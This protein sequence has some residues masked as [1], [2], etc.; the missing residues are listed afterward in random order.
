MNPERIAE[1]EA[2]A[3]EFRTLLAQA[4]EA[5]EIWKRDAVDNALHK[6]YLNT[7][8]RKDIDFEILKESLGVECD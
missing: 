3:T 6:M 2:L 7:K 8:R 1:L 5:Y 4:G